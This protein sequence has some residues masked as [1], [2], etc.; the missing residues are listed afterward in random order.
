[1]GEPCRVEVVLQI[2]GQVAHHVGGSCVNNGG[3]K[4]G[5]RRTK[6][7]VGSSWWPP[8][9]EPTKLGSEVR[10]EGCW[11]AEWHGVWCGG[12]GPT[13]SDRMLGTNL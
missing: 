3:T 4:G 13:S 2:D 8:Y 11:G 10:V 7:L 12:R 1:M 9:M 5:G 6:G